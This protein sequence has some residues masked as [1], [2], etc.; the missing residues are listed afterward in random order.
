MKSKFAREV[1]LCVRRLRGGKT[2]GVWT[3]LITCKRGVKKTVPLD[4]SPA[5]LLPAPPC[6]SRSCF[7]SPASSPSQRFPS[8]PP[9]Y[10]QRT[11]ASPCWFSGVRELL[12]QPLLA[13]L[14]HGPARSG[15]SPLRPAL[16]Q[17][18]PLILAPPSTPPP[19]VSLSPALPLPQLHPPPLNPASTHSPAVSPSSSLLV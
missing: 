1:G 14:S 2:L 15:F 19:I 7:Q 16:P 13:Q 5:L 9:A 6:F 18:P 11:P 10:S 8:P 17:P 4:P 12:L 3:F